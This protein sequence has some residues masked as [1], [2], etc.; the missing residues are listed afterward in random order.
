[1]PFEKVVEAV[2]PQ[3]S[4]SYAPLFQVKFTLNNAPVSKLDLAGVEIK[5]EEVAREALDLDV[6]LEMFETPDGLSGWINYS[7]DLFEASTIAVMATRFQTVLSSIITQPDTSVAGLKEMLVEINNQQQAT[8]QK[9]RE[10]SKFE[11]FKNIKPVA[12][13]L[14]QAAVVRTSNL[15]PDNP[16]PLF[17][18]PEAHDVDVVEWARDNRSLLENY[19]S[20][21]GGIVFRGFAVESAVQMERLSLTICHEL[22]Q[23]NGEHRRGTISNNVYTPVFYPR[24]Q[25]LLWHNEN[26]FNHRWPTRIWF[27]CVK[28]ALRGGE[29]PVVDSRRVY[30]ILDP[31]LRARFMAKGVMYV[32]N[33][34]GGLGLD[35]QDVFQTTSRREVEEKCTAAHMEFEWKKNGELRTRCVRPAAVRHPRTREWTW[36]NQ[37]QHWHVSCLDE[38]TREST[39]KLFREEDMPR[40]CY[41]GDGTRIADEDMASILEVYRQLEVSFPWQRGDVMVLDNLLTAHGRNRFEGERQLL[42]TMGDMRS[43]SEV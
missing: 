18:E 23:E 14:Q 24:E 20:T 37:A 31:E 25:Q 7:T 5:Q 8:N 41:Y 34:G 13:N 38:A 35:W 39:Q 30:E 6:Y 3:R 22:F 12:V 10:A 28:P 4:V 9:K 36:F 33:Y 27:C 42:V 32:R 43:Y 16:L 11:K 2:R 1:V 26:S 21:H 17:I 29:T 19:L 15:K 40:N